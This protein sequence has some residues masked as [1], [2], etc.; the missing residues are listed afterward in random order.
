MAGALD[1]SLKQAL[2]EI[3]LSLADDELLLGHRDSKWTGHAP[4]LEEDIAF[5]N[6][7]QDEMGHAAL[8]YDVSCS[9]S[10]DTPDRLVFFR[11]PEA[12]RNVQLVELPKG[13]WAFSMM[14]QY[15][16]DAYELVHLQR[17]ASSRFSPIADVA[18]KIRVE[19]LYHHRHTS[20]WIRRL[21][22]GTEESN[23]RTQR[24]LDELWSYAGQLFSMSQSYNE[25]I[26]AKLIPESDGLRQD[27]EGD[28]VPFLMESG[29]EI[30]DAGAINLSREEH[31]GHLAELLLDLQEVARK[32]PSLEW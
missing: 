17:L 1:S 31:S 7:A 23:R 18:A 9:L 19:E 3:T 27:W 16:F 12:F 13:D 28:V 32:F 25:L 5:S 2:V 6:I 20:Y 30:P 24:A 11:S 10:G 22:I 21:G 29:L 4:I 8:W 15:L 14:R 26:S